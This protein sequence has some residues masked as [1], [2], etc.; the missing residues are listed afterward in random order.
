MQ[1][2]RQ[3]VTE[4]HEKVT[5]MLQLFKCDADIVEELHLGFCEK[6]LESCKAFPEISRLQTDD[7]V[8]GPPSDSDSDCELPPLP[9]RK[10]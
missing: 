8:F 10:K 4:H 7:P 5:E 1:L 3:A 6:I 2:I 9:L